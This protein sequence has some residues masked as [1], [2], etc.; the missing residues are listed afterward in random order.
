[1]GG[2]SW[3]TDVYEQQQAANRA[4]GRSTFDYTDQ[5]RTGRQSAQVHD[6]VDPKWANQNG[7]HVGRNIREA[8]T[9]EDHPNPTAIAVVLDVTGSNYAAAVA[10]HNKLPQLHGLLQRKGYVE[11]P[12]ILF[13]AVG[14]AHTDSVP[15]QMGQFESDNRMDEQLAAIYLEGNGGGQVHETYELAAYFL[16]YHTYLETFERSSKKG[17]VFFIGDEKPYDAV[18][19]T[20]FGYAGHTLESL[21]GDQ[22]ESD[23]ST[24][25]VFAELEKRFNVF[26][27]FQEQGSYQAEE[28]LPVW[29]KLIG[30]RALRLDDPS[31]VCEVIGATLG[32]FE[33]GVDL[34]DAL[35]DLRQTG[36]DLTAVQAA[37]KALSTVQTGTVAA[38][39][40]DGQLSDLPDN[41]PTPRL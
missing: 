6:L 11:D 24:E 23:I 37:G 5:I 32:M 29:R 15:L 27:L 41:P 13:G 16:A 40:S 17:Y 14:D 10:A 7:P 25:Q 1:M 21:V 34:D 4:A 3:T 9:S 35:G 8:M 39:D 26:F 31:A 38:A 18:K 22:L 33:G 28:V 2:G 20:Y 36:S 19:R 12:Q 30:E